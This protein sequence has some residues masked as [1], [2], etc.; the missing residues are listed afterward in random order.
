MRIAELFL[1]SKQASQRIFRQSKQPTALNPLPQLNRFLPKHK[2]QIIQYKSRL[3]LELS[4]QAFIIPPTR[5][6][7]SVLANRKQQDSIWQMC[8]CRNPVLALDMIPTRCFLST[9][10]RLLPTVAIQY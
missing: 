4:R 5:N 8:I 1:R 6:P 9:T 10:N 3:S 2:S 7:V